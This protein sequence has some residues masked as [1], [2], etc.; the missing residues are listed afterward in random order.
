MRK[1]IILLGLGYLSSGMVAAETP[2]KPVVV[3][4]EEVHQLEEVTVTSDKTKKLNLRKEREAKES[5]Y[6]PRTTKASPSVTIKGDDVR[7]TSNAITAEDF[8]RKMPSVN[9]RQRYIGDVNSPMGIRDSN[10][11]Q[12]T[13]SLIYSDGM[14]LHNLARTSYNGSPRWGMVAPGEI[15]TAT[16]N[17]GPFSSQ[18]SGNSFGG[19]MTL[20]TKM[21]EKFEVNGSASGMLQPMDRAGR[22]QALPGTNEFLSIGNRWDKFSAYASYNHMYNE[23]QPMTPATATLTPSAHASTV[24]GAAFLVGPTTASTPVAMIGDDGVY[25]MT[26]DLYKLKL[27]Y[28]ITPDLQARFTGGFEHRDEINDNGQ[29]TLIGSNGQPIY[30][31]TTTAGYKAPS[32]TVYQN[33]KAFT[34]SNSAFGAT[35]FQRDSFSFATSLTGKI[36][37]DWKI[38]SAGSYYEVLRDRSTKS[39][40]SPNDPILNTAAGS[41]VAGAAVTDLKTWWGTYDLKLATDRFLGRDDLSFMGGYQ[42][43]RVGFGTNTYDTNAAYGA[44]NK[45]GSNAG[46]GTQMNSVFAQSSWRFMPDWEV[47]VGGRYDY[48]DALSGHNYIN[49]GAVGIPIPGSPGQTT[50]QSTTGARSAG[51]FSPKAS[52]EFTPDEWTF[53]YSFS[54]AYRFPVAEEMFSSSSSLNSSNIANPGL[55]PEAG[56]F[57]NVMVKYDIPRGFVQGDFFYNTIRNEINSSTQFFPSS[58]N[59]AATSVTT[60]LPI[61]K[62][63]AYGIDLMFQQKDIL[64]GIWDKPIDLNI[65]GTWIHKRILENNLNPAL[66][67]NQWN[68]IP[69][70]QANATLTYHMTPVWNSSV[71]VR[72][73]SFEYQT[74]TNIN[75]ASHVYGNTTEY[76]LVDLKTNYQ[77]PEVKGLKST[78]S[79]GVDN[80]LNQNVFENH[81]YPQRTF[82]VKASFKY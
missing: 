75:T 25:R 66:V 17:Y 8:V 72:Y 57:N 39:N 76:T 19:V 24:S 65:N 70:L 52:I 23:G 28:D 18:Y 44:A 41:Q 63:E 22:K 6:F 1:S 45:T 37:N 71:G 38:D 80:L 81:P 4:T 50:T 67:G 54:K 21:P 77:L 78:L 34:V 49:N 40:V 11:Y 62:T 56:I 74:I 82:F 5:R 33:G 15:D 26:T 35:H 58:I 29:S 12:T 2:K 43:Q 20:N 30:G 79:A 36:W 3:E 7:A 61:Q 48:W 68:Q 13:H 16:V 64:S 60:Y 51:R 53:R 73:R 14:P 47:T 46:G 27:G 55:G 42:F 59:G 32:L 69:K 9:I 31:N 10:A